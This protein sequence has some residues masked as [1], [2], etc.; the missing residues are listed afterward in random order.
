MVEPA[1]LTGAGDET[2]SVTRLLG[3]LAAAS[4]AEVVRFAERCPGCIQLVVGSSD[5]GANCS[6]AEFMQ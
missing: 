4:E 6:A 1:V 2:A 5:A 3:S